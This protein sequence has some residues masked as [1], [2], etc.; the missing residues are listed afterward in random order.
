MD[1]FQTTVTSLRIIWRFVDGCKSF[2]KDAAS[3]AVRLKYDERII[4]R[5]LQYFEDRKTRSQSQILSQDDENLLNELAE[6]LRVFLEGIESAR[7]KVQTRG[8]LRLRTQAMWALRAKDIQKL[9]KELYEW[10]QRFDVRLVALPANLK[11]LLDLS[12]EAATE[13]D[14]PGLFVLRQVETMKARKSQANVANLRC[15]PDA[16]ELRERTNRS[17]ES[18]VAEYKGRVSFVEYYAQSRLLESK[19]SCEELATILSMANP[20]TMGCLQCSAFFVDAAHDRYGLVYGIPS[21]L[22]PQPGQQLRTLHD[23]FRETNQTKRLLHPLNRRFHVAS[24]IAT[25]LLYVHAMGW[26]CMDLDALNSSLTSP[27]VHKSLKSDNILILE[28][29]QADAKH[30]F[31]YLIGSPYLVGFPYARQNTALSAPLA[32]QEA[33]TTGVDIYRHPGRQGVTP[34][35]RF[36]MCHDLYSLGVVLLE[37]GLWKAI[38]E[39]LGDFQ[40]KTPAEVKDKLLNMA[41][42][43]SVVMGRKYRDI[44]LTCL[45]IGENEE[46]GSVRYVQEILGKLEELSTVMN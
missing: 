21:H 41:Q 1:I 2:S 8:L 10:T 27:Q 32:F 22:S 38:D 35:E 11:T 33:S 17:L 23:L 46:V 4:V 19:D 9:E 29:N 24:M 44:V 28:G 43:L 34:A 6:Y 7:F 30:R 12:R 42:H 45:H 18:Y 37:I 26:V 3:L 20:V 16:V 31:P 5:I 39:K 40:G 25:A 36:S 15:E 13:Q 14:S